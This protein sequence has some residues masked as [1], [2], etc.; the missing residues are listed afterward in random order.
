MVSIFYCTVV[1][2]RC[3]AGRK[4]HL[5]T[6]SNLSWAQLKLSMMRLWQRSL[7]LS[8]RV[9]TVH[10]VI[11]A[12]KEKLKSFGGGAGGGGAVAAAGGGGAAATARVMSTVLQKAGG[13]SSPE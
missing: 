7:F 12:G 13:S 3:L 5:Q 4:A 10:E 9:Q 11:A 8:C 6:T 1:L 2:P